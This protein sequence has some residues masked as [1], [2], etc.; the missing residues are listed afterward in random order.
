VWGPRSIDRFL[1][2]HRRPTA[3]VGVILVLG[4]VVLNA[5]EALPEHHH[6]HGESTMCVAAL[7]IAVLAAFGWRPKRAAVAGAPMA[8]VVLPRVPSRPSAPRIWGHARAGPRVPAVL[9]R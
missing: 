5:H 7:S 9:R 2:S 6:D 3:L 8:C 4:V 1:S